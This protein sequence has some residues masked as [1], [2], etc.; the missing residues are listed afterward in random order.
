MPQEAVGYIRVSSE[1][2]VDGDG[3]E[4]QRRVI[5]KWAK[6]TKTTIVRDYTDLG[7]SGTMDAD[8]R[9]G[10][11]QMLADL[12]AFGG[13]PPIVVIERADRLARDLMVSEMILQRLRAL[14]VRLILA[15]NGQEA[16][17]YTPTGTMVRQILGAVSEFEKASIVA[18]LRVAREVARQKHGRCEGRKPYG[19]KPGEAAGL[20]IILAGRRAGLSLERIKRQLDEA[21]IPARGSEK[22]GPKPW[23]RSSIA[24]ILSAHTSRKKS[25]RAAKQ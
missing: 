11:A 19:T 16:A 13:H 9:P 15:E 20:E 14:G 21:G 5:E 1:G 6:R 8:N 24:K 12:A 4:R 25:S 2:Q 22:F 10:M 7:V 3:P 17:D 23:A 18:K